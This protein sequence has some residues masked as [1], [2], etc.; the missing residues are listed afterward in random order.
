MAPHLLA[1]GVPD[2]DPFIV[3]DGPVRLALSVHHP[4]DLSPPQVVLRIACIV[5]T[6][7][8]EIGS[9]PPIPIDAPRLFLRFHDAP[10]FCHSGAVDMESRSKVARNTTS[11]N[12]LSLSR[13]VAY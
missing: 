13:D 1:V 8:S 10:F 11:T 2:E 12:A 7:A 4:E 5:P 3:I 9:H 6:R